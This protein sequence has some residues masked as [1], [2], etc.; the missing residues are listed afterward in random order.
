MKRKWDRDLRIVW[1]VAIALLGFNLTA[2]LVAAIAQAWIVFGTSLLWASTCAV[3][4]F[5][6]IPSQQTTRTQ[7][8][9]GMYALTQQQM[10]WHPLRAGTRSDARIQ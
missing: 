5:A 9:A 10:R 8:R 1:C 7:S 6:L 3:W 4:A 2:A